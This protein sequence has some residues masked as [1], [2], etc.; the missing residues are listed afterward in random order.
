VVSG[1]P[2]H[3]VMAP[4][5]PSAIFDMCEAIAADA[6]RVMAVPANATLVHG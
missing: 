3:R 1:A 6:K 2:V 4:A 5:E